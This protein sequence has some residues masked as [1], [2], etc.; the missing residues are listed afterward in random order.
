MAAKWQKEKTEEPV[1]RVNP[2]RELLSRALPLGELVIFT[3]D[4]KHGGQ[5]HPTRSISILKLRNSLL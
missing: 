2:A 4:I 3:V 5:A 1:G